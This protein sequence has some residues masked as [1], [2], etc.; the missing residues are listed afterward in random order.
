MD[1][2]MY[3]PS[4][5]S[6]V[7]P[8][9]QAQ[10]ALS[11]QLAILNA[12]A[13]EISRAFN[14]LSLPAKLPPEILS[15]IF[16]TH[17]V[18]VQQAHLDS[19]LSDR[20]F[21]AKVRSYYKWIY[22]AHVCRHWREVAL[23]CAE[24]KAFAV[25][26]SWT[27]PDYKLFDSD[28]KL[29]GP[30]PLTVVYHQNDWFTPRCPRC[31]DPRHVSSIALD[32]MRGLLA[33]RIKHL[34]I[35]IESDF[36]TLDL[37]KRLAR[38][39]AESLETLRIGLRGEAWTYHTA[40]RASMLTIPD[41][42]FASSTPRLR[43]LSTSYV[44]FSWTNTL[45]CPSLQHLEVTAHPGY[46]PSTDFAEF[47]S[48]LTTL[49]LLESLVLDS[50]PDMG[51]S[52]DAVAHLPRLRLLQVTSVMDRVT[53]LLSHLRLP[54]STSVSMTLDIHQVNTPTAF[55]TFA[56]EVSKLFKET[57]PH[58][59]SWSIPDTGYAGEFPQIS[60]QGSR[61]K[62][63]G[64]TV[65][66][67][68]DLWVQNPDIAPRLSLKL[69]GTKDVIRLL[70]HVPLTR[71]EALHVIGP[72]PSS[73][74][75]TQHFAA[76]SDLRLLRVT[77][78]VGYQLGTALSRVVDRVGVAMP[79]LRALE[80]ANVR[81]P[82]PL[83]PDDYQYAEVCCCDDCEYSHNRWGKRGIDVR[84]LVRGLRGRRAQGAQD[85]E[86]ISFLGCRFMKMSHMQPL[87]RERS[88]VVFDGVVLN[89]E[90]SV[91]H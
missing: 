76:A 65:A 32:R 80:F 43:S 29:W 10:A 51:P 77:G 88:T 13:L 14:A 42:L 4:P 79:R 3:Q 18:R 46:S 45:L 2:P 82:P 55:G 87:L 31:R 81:F 56:Q 7:P 34:A 22:V 25:F 33:R 90:V 23:S 53:F 52:I 84:D 64:K 47:I 78:R 8:P 73:E 37:W 91:G 12:Q 49:P 61:L 24:F 9:N 5:L 85:V 60:D 41:E 11:A 67:P 15:E 74:H 38:R 72:M 26:E 6:V 28:L 48:A 36:G 30:Y 59:M 54:P 19:I 20:D 75:W 16:L 83:D 86:R 21:A 40:D 66:A 44:S 1:R 68:Q 89:A 39:P 70:H 71:L 58:T 69:R 35:I 50:L 62:T 57:P 63:W 27:V 17:A